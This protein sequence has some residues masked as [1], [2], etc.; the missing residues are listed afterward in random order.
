VNARFYDVLDRPVVYTLVQRLLAPGAECLVL[1]QIRELMGRVPH[2][3]SLLDVGCGPASWLLR[4]QV[5]P[6]GL[7]INPAYVAAYNRLGCPGVVASAT[8]MPFKDRSFAGVW[9]IGLL[10]HLPD[11]MAKRALCEAIRVC[12]P[13]GYV[14]ILDAVTPVARWRRPLA[15]VI[16]AWD[17]GKFMRTEQ[18]LQALLPNRGRWSCHRFTAAITGLEMLSCVYENAQRGDSCS[19]AAVNGVDTGETMDDIATSRSPQA[20]P[21]GSRQT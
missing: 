11:E 20:K 10:H 1:R 18:G 16:R 17:R 9:S 12:R 14:A 5:T 21:I 13:G 7:D 6:L 2:G 19:V 8:H 3:E 4:V 15:S